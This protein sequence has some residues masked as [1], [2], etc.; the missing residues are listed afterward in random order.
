MSGERR[1]ESG[2]EG[3]IRADRRGDIGRL[4]KGEKRGEDQKQ[5]YTLKASF[6]PSCHRSR[7]R[8]RHASSGP[9]PAPRR[10]IN[11]SAGRVAVALAAVA[12]A[13]PPPPACPSAWP[14]ADVAR[15]WQPGFRCGLE[16]PAP[17]P[18]QQRRLRAVAGSCQ[19]IRHLGRCLG[20]A[21]GAARGV[22]H[23]PP[24]PVPAARQRPSAAE[25][26][27]GCTHAASGSG[28]SRSVRAAPAEPPSCAEPPQ[29][30]RGASAE[31]L[32]SFRGA[33]AEPPRNLHETSRSFAGPR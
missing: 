30:L 11:F 15:R 13:A 31:P 10:P 33:S 24:G 9:P 1:G 5:D 26:R 14:T 27:V 19:A 12:A 8:P 4:E 22:A 3:D 32:R 25:H 18:V 2:G 23:A 17:P 29:S 21:Q 28:V 6:P 7:H 16:A 20:A